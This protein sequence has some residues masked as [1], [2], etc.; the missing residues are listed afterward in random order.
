MTAE[1]R[2]WLAFD[3][4]QDHGTRSKKAEAINRLQ[5]HA[6][7]IGDGLDADPSSPAVISPP[8]RSDR[9]S[10]ADEE[11]PGDDAGRES[12][13]P[14]RKGVQST[15]AGA[16]QQQQQPQS[17][18]PATTQA[19]TNAPSA[20]IQAQNNGAANRIFPRPHGRPN[21]YTNWLFAHETRFTNL[22][23][24]WAYRHMARYNCQTMQELESIA[25]S[26][27]HFWNNTLSDHDWDHEDPLP[28]I[29]LRAANFQQTWWH[30]NNAT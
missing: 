5:R 26:L 25:E 19:N 21:Q 14:R 23:R 27:F 8:P 1:T 22:F 15:K 11:G 20:P 16:Q 24:T 17:Q 9:Q 2:A 4:G 12:K 29:P 28:S 10:H 13:R 6:T 18:F 7:D 3:L 30:V